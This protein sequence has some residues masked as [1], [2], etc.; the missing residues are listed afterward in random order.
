MEHICAVW[1]RRRRQKKQQHGSTLKPV[2]NTGTHALP[3]FVSV[4]GLFCHENYWEFSFILNSINVVSIIPLD[5]NN[6]TYP[7]CKSIYISIKCAYREAVRIE[8]FSPCTLCLW[9]LMRCLLLLFVQSSIFEH[10]PIA[11][12]ATC[13]VWHRQSIFFYLSNFAFYCSALGLCCCCYRC[14]RTTM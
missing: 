9:K 6:I 8:S 13:C 2:W 5:N 10:T 1:Q 7:N 12:P 11:P 3:L 14:L 4:V